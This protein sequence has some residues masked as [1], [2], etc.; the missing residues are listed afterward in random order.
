[1]T[2]IIYSISVAEASSKAILP[3]KALAEIILESREIASQP[4]A[5]ENNNLDHLVHVFCTNQLHVG[6]RESYPLFGTK[7]GE[8]RKGYDVDI[9]KAIA[10]TL[11][12]GIA[13][14]KVNASTRIPFVNEGRIDLV[15]A[16]MGHN[17]Q[18]DGQIR[19]IRP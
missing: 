18:R 11:G 19:Y 12:V 7:N 14:Q 3:D 13:F 4:G 15:L 9:G 6:V 2:F 1:M 5:C 8:I 10:D 16:T 17:I